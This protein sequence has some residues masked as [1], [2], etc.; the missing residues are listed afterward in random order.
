MSDWY[1]VYAWAPMCLRIRVCPRSTVRP[2]V[3]K[4]VE[5]LMTSSQDR[6]C[7]LCLVLCGVYQHLGP[8]PAACRK[9]V[10]PSG[11]SEAVAPH[12]CG[13]PGT[14]EYITIMV[15]V[16]RFSKGVHFLPFG[17]TL[18]VAGLCFSPCFY[19]MAFRKTLSSIRDV[20]SVD[21][22]L[23]VHNHTHIGVSPGINWSD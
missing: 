14:K 15:V 5:V 9:V 8:P 18:H 20:P 11:S 17:S 4:T 16:D 10:T 2:G 21:C 7:T 19:T 1:G 12:S 23:G 3:R 22:I 6:C 13:L